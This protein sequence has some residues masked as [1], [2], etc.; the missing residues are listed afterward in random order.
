DQAWKHLARVRE[1][2]LG[3]FRFLSANLVRRPGYGG[4]AGHRVRALGEGHRIGP[5][6]RTWYPGGGLGMEFWSVPLSFLEPSPGIRPGNT[7]PGFV[8]RILVRSVFCPRIWSGGRALATLSHPGNEILVGSV[9]HSWV[10]HLTSPERDDF[11]PKSEPRSPGGRMRT[12]QRASGVSSSSSR[13]TLG[14]AS[15]SA[16]PRRRAHARASR[17]NL[18]PGDGPMTG[19]WSVPY[20]RLEPISGGQARLHLVRLPGQNLGRFRFLSANLTRR[21]DLGGVVEPPGMRFWSDP[22]LIPGCIL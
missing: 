15:W 20:P 4:T 16:S 1:Q 5:T 12:T 2:N 22:F 18:A 3:P 11:V 17:S 21:P 10:H 6:G 7:W 8:D 14:P 9:S 19:Y 13:I